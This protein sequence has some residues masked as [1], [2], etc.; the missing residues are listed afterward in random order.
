MSKTAVE[1]ARKKF[2]VGSTV[3][4]DYDDF[5][6]NRWAIPDYKNACD[7]IVQN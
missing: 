1:A 5:I 2:P 7:E 4:V 3:V 6:V